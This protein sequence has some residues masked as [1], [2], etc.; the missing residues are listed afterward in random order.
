MLQSMVSQR[1]GHDLVIGQQQYQ[2]RALITLT[3]FFSFW[4][5]ISFSFLILGD[6]SLPWLS[7][8]LFFHQTG[9]SKPE[10]M[11]QY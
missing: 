4:E 2:F 9:T 11:R 3:H 7:Q 8:I 6:P 5:G 1:A 10:Q